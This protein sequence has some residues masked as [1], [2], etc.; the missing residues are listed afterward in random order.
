MESDTAAA[1]RGAV[2]KVIVAVLFRGGLR[3]SEAAALRSADVQD[4][5]DG[6]GIVVYVRRSKTDQDGTAADVR[7]L[8]NGCA[9][10]IR[11]LRDRIT[12]QRSG[13]ASGRH[14]AGHRTRTG[15]GSWSLTFTLGLH[16]RISDD[17]R[18]L[19]HRL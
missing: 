1:E 13:F 9:A 7:Y 6:R 17:G 2:D 4:A 14:G 8:K 11:Q 10:A 15:G 12:V 18:V 5:A 3:R 16:P 19:H